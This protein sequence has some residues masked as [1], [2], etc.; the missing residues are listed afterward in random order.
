VFFLLAVLLFVL[1]FV[2]GPLGP[3]LLWLG[4][5]I[6]VGFDA[7]AHK[8]GEYQNPLGG[9]GAAVAGSLL[10]WIVVFPWYLAIRSRIRAGVQPV[11]V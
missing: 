10:L 9:P 7:G 3:T 6:W 8:L 5:S 1:S 4:T 11:K 2:L